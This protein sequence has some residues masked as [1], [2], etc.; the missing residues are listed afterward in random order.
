ME[1]YADLG[2]VIAAGGVSRRYGIGNKLTEMLGD[3]PVLLHP[4]R[5]YAPVAQQIVLVAAAEYINEYRALARQYL[6]EVSA[7][8]VTGGASRAESV[9][10]GLAALAENIRVAAVAD[11]ARPLG[12]PAQLQRLYREAEKF[13][14]G[15]ISGRYVRD[16]L[17]HVD[18]Q[19]QI[20]EP[21][22]REGVFR[23]ETPQLF[24]VKLLRAALEMFHGEDI[25]DDA[26]AMRRAG[27]T[28]RVCPDPEPN[29]KLTTPEDYRQLRKLFILPE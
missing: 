16:S 4:L 23:A 11:A 29:P 22:A 14:T 9:L 8:F 27:Y 10:N 20:L 24:P 7:Q 3:L 6:P 17:K 1:K 2:V 18:A 12:S 26:E 5:S 15:V 21:V 13:S 19:G 25:T 28:V